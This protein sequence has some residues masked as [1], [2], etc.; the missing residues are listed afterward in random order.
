M[1]L[2]CGINITKYTDTIKGSFTL[3][4]LDGLSSAGTKTIFVILESVSLVN[5]SEMVDSS[6]SYMAIHRELSTIL[7]PNNASEYTREESNAS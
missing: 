2:I 6:I 7:I 4:K 1:R 5:H 3:G